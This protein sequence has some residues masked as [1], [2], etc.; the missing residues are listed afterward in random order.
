MFLC[1]FSVCVCMC[2]QT[3]LSCS[4]YI[5]TV[6]YIPVYYI[7][8]DLANTLQYCHPSLSFLPQIDFKLLFVKD[9][10]L[11]IDIFRFR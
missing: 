3:Y 11:P 10:V 4:E 1:V 2:A 7:N 6:L 8:L 9:C 5:M